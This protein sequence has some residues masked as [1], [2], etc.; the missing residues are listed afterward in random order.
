[1]HT[2]YDIELGKM[3]TPNQHQESSGESRI[4]KMRKFLSSPLMRKKPSVLQLKT[5]GIPLDILL[6]RTPSDHSI[7]FIITRL[8]QYI[9]RTGLTQEGLFRIS[10]NAR[11][12]ERLRASFDRSG[13]APLETEGDVPSAAALLKLFLRELP[14]PIIP[15]AMH[16]QFLNAVKDKDKEESVACLTDLVE[17]LPSVNY[18]I[19]N[20]LSSFL[21]QVSDLEDQNRMSASSLG[22]VFGPNLFRVT[23]DLVGLKEQSLTNQIVTYFIT[24]YQEIFKKE[25]I[26]MCNTC[27]SST[28]INSTSHQVAAMMSSWPDTKV[29]ST[30]VLSTWSL[31]GPISVQIQSA[32]DSCLTLSS[33]AHSMENPITSSITSDEQELAYCSEYPLHLNDKS[34]YEA[35]VRE[36]HSL[37]SYVERETF[38]SFKTDSHLK[39]LMTTDEEPMLSHSVIKDSLQVVP[40]DSSVNFENDEALNDKK[41][42]LHEVLTFDVNKEGAYSRDF[43]SKDLEVHS[44]MTVEKSVEMLKDS[45]KSY[46]HGRRRHIKHHKKGFDVEERRSRSELRI[47]SRLH[48]EDEFNGNSTNLAQDSKNELQYSSTGTLDENSPETRH[49]WPAFRKTREEDIALSPLPQKLEMNQSSEASVSPSAFRTYLSHRNLH[50]DPSLP[51][52]PPVEQEDLV[53]GTSIEISPSNSKLLSRKIHALKKKIKLFEELYGSQSSHTEKSTSIAMKKMLAELNKA[54]QDLK[55]LKEEPVIWDACETTQNKNSKA[56]N[57]RCSQGLFSLGSG[58]SN[59]SIEDSVK[60]ALEF[61]ARHRKEGKRPEALELWSP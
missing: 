7:P 53:T 40:V 5:F 13:D 55:E 30:S 22:I 10:G 60:E 20:Y 29:C 12:V 45:H 27:F 56:T 2:L 33:L 31:V 26:F 41:E 28:S 19:L 44:P 57:T 6:Q 11:S 1:M 58:N 37:S 21:K 32:D 4:D 23:E 42:K 47:T 52:S 9:Q 46:P 39:D 3:L 50:L 38:M 54:R 25:D 14:D 51:P 36:S 16:C 59:M 48:N 17:K 24:D 43:N 8:C 35:N 49:S 34:S 18:S 61:L 15:L